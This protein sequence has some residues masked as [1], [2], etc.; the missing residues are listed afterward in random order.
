M[1]DLPHV[2]RRPVETAADFGLSQCN[3]VVQSSERPDPT[4][5]CRSATRSPVSAFSAVADHD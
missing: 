3:M 5:N 2:S 4:L 1:F